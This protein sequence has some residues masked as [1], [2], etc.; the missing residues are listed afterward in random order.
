MSLNVINTA[1]KCR[2]TLQSSCHLIHTSAAL[3]H[4]TRRTH[5]PFWWAKKTNKADDD[6]VTPA[7]KAFIEQMKKASFIDRGANI[8]LQGHAK[9]DVEGQSGIPYTPLKAE[10]QPWLEKPLGEW[11]P[12]TTSYLSIQIQGVNKRLTIFLL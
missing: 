9:A 12:H 5:K 1:F 3:S 10:L 11:R 2:L 4:K 7:N 8:A 6:P